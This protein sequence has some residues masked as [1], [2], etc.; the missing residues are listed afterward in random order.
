VAYFIAGS[1]FIIL[2]IVWWFIQ[3]Q[4]ERNKK[5]EEAT[6]DAKDAV[7]KHDTAGL[8]AGIRERMLRR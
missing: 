4:G 8:F 1:I 3:R 7:K 6:R 2:S 5:H